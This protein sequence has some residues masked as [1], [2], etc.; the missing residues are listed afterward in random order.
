MHN[1]SFNWIPRWKSALLRWPR[2]VGAFVVLGA[3]TVWAQTSNGPIT[4][5]SLSQRIDALEK[6]MASAIRR[7][8]SER[9][10]LSGRQ[11]CGCGVAEANRAG[12]RVAT[13]GRAS[14][15]RPIHGEGPLPHRRSGGSDA[16]DRDRRR[17]RLRQAGDERGERQGLYHRHRQH[18]DPD[19]RLDASDGSAYI[20][21]PTGKNSGVRLFEPGTENTVGA[22]TETVGGGAVVAVGI[23]GIS[24]VETR[25]DN[26]GARVG[27]LD[28]SGQKYVSNLTTHGNGGGDLEL[29][30]PSGQVVAFMDANPVNNEGCAVFTSAGGEPLAKIGAAGDHGDVLLGGLRR[31]SRCGKWH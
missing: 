20:G 26:K 25:V 27:I 31:A 21:S 9:R 15:S 19:V 24:K 28:N 5:Q 3:L 1:D 23:H 10:R 12:G 17:S 13:G 30:N 22:I 4:L 6:R 29:A 18:G 14:Q 2:T 7:R 8:A 11:R 16:V